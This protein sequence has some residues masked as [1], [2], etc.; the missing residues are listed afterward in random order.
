MAQPPQLAEYM[1]GLINEAIQAE[2]HSS[3]LFLSERLHAALPTEESSVYYLALSLLRSNNAIGAIEVLKQV[4]KKPEPPGAAAIKAQS[5]ARTKISG[6]TAWR[7]QQQMK[8]ACQMSVRCAW[9]YAKACGAVGRSREG[10]EMLQKAVDKFSK[11]TGL[12]AEGLASL[13]ITL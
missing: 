10:E 9:V 5:P 7:Q 13:P 1:I 8:P 6:L 11:G 2:L 12:K 3:A 4:V